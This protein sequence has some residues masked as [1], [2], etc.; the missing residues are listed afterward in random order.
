[1]IV[2]SG[3]YYFGVQVKRQ[4]ANQVKTL[5]SQ[6]IIDSP[7]NTTSST[8][9]TSAATPSAAVVSEDNW[10]IYTNKKFGFSLKY[11]GFWTEEDPMSGDDNTLVYLNANES[12]GGEPEPVQ[13]YVWV[14]VVDRLPE[15]KLREESVTFQIGCT[16]RLYFKRK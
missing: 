10:K 2:V 11:P 15:A 9:T 3:V 6:P 13:Y 8:V 12:F 1:M 7:A 5:N 4:T 16:N 14:T